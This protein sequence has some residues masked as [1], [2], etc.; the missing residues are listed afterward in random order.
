MLSASAGLDMASFGALLEVGLVGA[1]DSGTFEDK[2]NKGT[3]E[4]GLEGAA[5]DP[6]VEGTVTPVLLEGV[7]VEVDVLLWSGRRG[8][9]G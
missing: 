3:G 9:E 5:A 2:S 4:W 6:D 7:A 8:N 1:V